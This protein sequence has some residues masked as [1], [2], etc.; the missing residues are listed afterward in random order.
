MIQNHGPEACRSCITRW[1]STLYHRSRV[2]ESLDHHP[3][4]Q[5]WHQFVRACSPVLALEQ[6]PNA[7]SED[8]DNVR[9]P[10]HFPTGPRSVMTPRRP[11][12]S[13]KG[14][15]GADGWP[16]YSVFLLYDQPSH[17]WDVP[18]LFQGYS[19]RTLFLPSRQ[20]WVTSSRWSFLVVP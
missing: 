15:G 8:G 12:A 2:D 11:S 9:R 6:L 19:S 13:S 17:G 5:R 7:L 16:T 14:R 4:R 1:W 18:F 3:W 10:T 20:S